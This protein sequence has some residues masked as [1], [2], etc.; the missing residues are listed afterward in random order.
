MGGGQNAP[1][2]DLL[3]PA[4]TWKPN[5]QKLGAFAEALG[6][7][8]SGNFQDLPRVTYFEAWNEPSLSLFLNPQFDGKERVAPEHYRKM[9]NAFYKGV[10]EG[11]KGA[12]VIAGS[13][14]PFGSDDPDGFRIRPLDFMRE[15]LCVKGRKNFER[16]CSND[17]K[18]DVYSH[19]PINLNGD[20]RRSALDFD[21]ISAAADMDRI[22]DVLRAAERFGTTTPGRHPVWAT[23]IWW[24]TE[25]PDPRDGF[26][27]NDQA[28][29]YQ[30]AMY[31]LDK[32][33]VSAMVLLQLVDSPF[34][35]A[36][37][38]E[39]NGFQSGIFFVDGTPKPSL[40]AFSFPFVTERRSKSEILAWTIPPGTGK[41]VIQRRT[42]GKW[43]TVE[44]DQV[45]GDRPYQTTLRLQG[46]AKLRASLG[47]ETSL[48]WT[49]KAGN[50]GGRSEGSGGAGRSAGS[51]P[52]ALAPYVEAPR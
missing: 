13:T 43:K 2:N 25:P 10:N 12:K 36:P 7:R 29:W 26:S 20:P 35:P 50:G 22:V 40:T 46:S 16:A 28:N 30:E 45:R 47:D 19:H 27:L 9:L 21:D 39:R 8:Y 38:G 17:A 42:G 6:R 15:L 1:P 33:G 4:G 48:T 3:H 52:A 5:P 34:T 18:F 51:H 41:L 11:N 49:Q 37:R 24:E 31:L 23:E 32:N 14:G 44:Q